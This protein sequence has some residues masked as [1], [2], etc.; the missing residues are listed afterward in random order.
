MLQ[1]GTGARKTEIRQADA[2]R[3][4]PQNLEE[5]RFDGLGSQRRT[6][7]DG[8]REQCGRAEDN[9]VD[10][11]LTLRRA[12][13]RKRM[14]VDVATKQRTLEEQ[15]GAGPNRRPPTEPWEDRLAHQGLN[16]KEQKRT[17]EDRQRKQKNL[18]CPLGSNGRRTHV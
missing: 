16:L 5:G 8:E 14:R 12:N 2:E 11:G 4:H 7:N 6:G 9:Q 1:Q 15:H 3:E 18:K 17:H 10:Q 13:R